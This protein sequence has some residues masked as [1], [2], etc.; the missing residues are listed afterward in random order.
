MMFGLIVNAILS[1]VAMVFIMDQPVLQHKQN[2]WL[3]F[4]QIPTCSFKKVEFLCIRLCLILR[5]SVER[6]SENF[7]SNSGK[8]RHEESG[9]GAFAWN[10]RTSCRAKAFK[11]IIV[12]VLEALFYFRAERPKATPKYPR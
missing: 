2:N 8:L 1:I 11:W 9:D 10:L 7:S 12:F 6:M 4:N 3:F 5:C